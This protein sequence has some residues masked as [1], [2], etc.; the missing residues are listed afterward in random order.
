MVNELADWSEEVTSKE[1]TRTAAT[2]GQAGKG[3]SAASAKPL[4]PIRNRVDIRNSLAASEKV[5]QKS[6]A[7]G[8]S[9]YKEDVT[10]RDTTPM[11]DYYKA[12]DKI[13]REI[14]ELDSSDEDTGDATRAK[15]P[16]FREE[17]KSQAEMFKPT[18]GAAPNTSIVVKGA[19]QQQLSFAEECK[20]QGNAY[21]V[22]LDYSK[23]IECYTRCLNN[24]QKDSAKI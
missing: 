4:P 2:K 9:N 12:W 7:A 16:K 5:S 14:E 18:S 17:N 8:K 1:K 13:G 3:G 22:S 15:N 19:R 11:P 10:K 24:I 21:F 23:A 20:L 6:T